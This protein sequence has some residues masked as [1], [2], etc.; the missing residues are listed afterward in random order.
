[1]IGDRDHPIRASSIPMLMK[2]PKRIS[3]ELRSE[4]KAAD[5]GTAVHAAIEAWHQTHD[6]EKAVTAMKSLSHKF[7]LADLHDAELSA[8]PYFAD[9]R[10]AKGS[11]QATEHKVEVAIEGWDGDDP[12]Y[13]TGTLDQVREDGIWDVKHS[14]KGG[15]ELIHEY[16]YQLAA[17]A[18]AAR[19]PV[20]GIITPKGYR[21]RGAELPSPGGVF[22]P[23]CWQQEHVMQLLENFRRMVWRIRRGEVPAL[24]GVHCGHCPA[25][26]FLECVLR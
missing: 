2:C 12:I 7:P 14:D 4:S 5:T 11:V 23:T 25:G 24:P 22:W 10:N 20:G 17:Y 15:F 19:K 6:A 3:L 8:R 18:Y 21:K 26:S 1:M 13:V 9:P 16:A